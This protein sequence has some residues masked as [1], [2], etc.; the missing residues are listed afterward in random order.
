MTES[1]CETGNV[2]LKD[3][4]ALVDDLFF[5]EKIRA[6]GKGAGI[7]VEIMK[8]GE[9]LIGRL[10]KV[11]P[12]LVIVDLNETATNPIQTIQKIKSDPQLL[13]VPILGFFSHVQEDLKRK[14]LQAGCNTVLPRSSF[15]RNLARI[16]TEYSNQ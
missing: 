14:A 12:G 11:S 4:F 16:L 9:D 5:V 15:S 8:S 13:G 6:T 3:I 10:R 1:N 2:T 7:P